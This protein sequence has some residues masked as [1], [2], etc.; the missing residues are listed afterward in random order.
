MQHVAGVVEDVHAV[1]VRKVAGVAGRDDAVVGAPDHQG[2]NGV[3]DAAR[4]LGLSGGVGEA[5][6]TTT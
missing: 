4:V 1:L 2:G 3:D 5:A 6:R